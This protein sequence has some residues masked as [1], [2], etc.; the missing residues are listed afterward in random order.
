MLNG[1]IHD[2]WGWSIDL[3]RD[4]GTPDSEIRLVVSF[5]HNKVVDFY[6]YGKDVEMLAQ[7]FE[8]PLHK[9]H[10]DYVQLESVSYQLMKD[11]KLIEDKIDKVVNKINSLHND[12]DI[13]E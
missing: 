1:P 2:S 9:K 5:R 6:I 7:E 4:F 11:I 8:V 3:Y 12:S 10:E 13:N